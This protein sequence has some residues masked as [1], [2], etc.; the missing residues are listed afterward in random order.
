MGGP[1]KTPRRYRSPK[2]EAMRRATRQSVITAAGRLFS[3]RGYAGS[4][5]EAIAGAAGVAVPTVYAAFGNK[6]SILRATIDATVD[7]ERPRPMAERLRDQAA[8]IQDPATRVH[9]LMRLHVSLLAQSA[10]VR[11]VVRGAAATDPEIQSL[12][13]EVYSRVYTACQTSACLAL[14]VTSDDARTRRLADVMF[15]FTSSDLF[16]LLTGQR[17]WSVAEYEHWAIQ[18]VTAALP[19]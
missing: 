12:L 15:A 14:G 4:S 19:A 17:G 11:R 1:V 6:R 9:K 10:D 5:I 16:D 13:A 3:E 2:H 8:G 18:T 7:G